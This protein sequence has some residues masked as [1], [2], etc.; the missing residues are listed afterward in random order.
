MGGGGINSQVATR[1]VKSAT[2]EVHARSRAVQFTSSSSVSIGQISKCFQQPIVT[3][4][5]RPKNARNACVTKFLTPSAP[6]FTANSI[7]LFSLTLCFVGNISSFCRSLLH[8]DLNTSANKAIQSWK[9]R[10]LLNSNCEKKKC[11]NTE[12]T[13]FHKVRTNIPTEADI[14]ECLWQVYNITATPSDKW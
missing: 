8:V 12:A 13:F 9:R 14:T 1:R 7:K 2:T 3:S 10:S 4:F 11:Y 5:K 6:H